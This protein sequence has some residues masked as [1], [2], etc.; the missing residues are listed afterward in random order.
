LSGYFITFKSPWNYKDRRHPWRATSNHRPW[1]FPTFIKSHR[2]SRFPYLH[3][4]TR[5]CHMYCFD[6][7]EIS[8]EIYWNWNESIVFH[9]QKLSGP[10]IKYIHT[11]IQQK[12]LTI[13]I[14]M[15]KKCSSGWH[16]ASFTS[17]GKYPW[18]LWVKILHMHFNL[19]S[20]SDK[21]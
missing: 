9:V 5:V 20:M 2:L 7:K 17:C 12:W 15:N 13:C 6:G 18:K 8:V 1:C 4:R 3:Y 11:C 14:A 21:H 16:I 19:T 10:F